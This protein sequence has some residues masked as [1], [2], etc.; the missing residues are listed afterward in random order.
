MRLNGIKAEPGTLIG[1]DY[2]SLRFVVVDSVDY[3]FGFE[4]NL[5]FATAEEVNPEVLRFK[6]PRSVA[7]HRCIKRTQ[8]PYGLVRR[9]KPMPTKGILDGV[10]SR[11]EIRTR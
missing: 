10:N 5:R 6:N 3:S 7:E 1:M 9:F 11:T 4:M 2:K 8:T